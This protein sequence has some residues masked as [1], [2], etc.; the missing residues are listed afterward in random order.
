[1]IDLGAPIDVAGIAIDPGAGCGD[2]WRAGLKTYA[3]NASTAPDAGW[4][5]LNSAP[6]SFLIADAGRLK[7]VEE[8]S[9]D[10]VRFIELHVKTPQGNSQYIDVSEIHVAKVPGTLR[11]PTTETGAAQ[12]VSTR[13][14]RLTGTVNPNGRSGITTGFQYGTSKDQLTTITSAP[15]GTGSAPVPVTRD[16]SGLQANTTYHFR[17]VAYRDGAAYPGAF[18]SFKTTVSPPPPTPTPTPTPRPPTPAPTPPPPPPDPGPVVST[19]F[20]STRLSADRRGMFKVQW[21]FGDAAPA[22]NATIRVVGKRRK[23]IA[24]ARVAVR[25]GRTIT[26]TLRLNR[27]GRRMIKRGKSRRVTLELRLPGGGALRERVRLS[28]KR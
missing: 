18:A 8:T 17:F 12:L 15:V 23:R 20:K 1:V 5:P 27:G 6:P 14:A 11:G 10:D 16:L 22:G 3:L 26:K 2:D 21:T 13:T 24:S 28:R 19:A 25:P 7:D 9:A 4:F